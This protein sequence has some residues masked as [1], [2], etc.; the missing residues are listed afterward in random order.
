M[1]YDDVTHLSAK[2]K[3]KQQ[4]V[5]HHLSPVCK[6]CLMLGRMYLRKVYCAINLLKL[7]N[8]FQEQISMLGGMGESF[9]VSVKQRLE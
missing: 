9:I 2:I 3:P 1:T 4:K 7:C 5:G 8:Y 6:S